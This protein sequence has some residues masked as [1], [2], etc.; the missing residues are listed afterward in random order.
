MKKTLTAI[1]ASLAIGCGINP[2]L[3]DFNDKEEYKVFKNVT[4]QVEY[5]KEPG[6]ENHWQKPEETRKIGF[7]DCEDLTLLLIDEWY[8]EGIKGKFVIGY[9]TIKDTSLHCWAE[10]PINDITYIV[11]PSFDVF[12]PRQRLPKHL[13]LKLIEVER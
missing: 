3:Y 10:L 8:K 12:M 11:D 4:E 1:V 5:R 6:E 7:G 2:A 13:Y 9:C